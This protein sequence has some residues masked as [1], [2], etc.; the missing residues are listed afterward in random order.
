LMSAPINMKFVV[1]FHG[2][3]FVNESFCRNAKA[4]F[5]VADREC[6]CWWI[7][8]VAYDMPPRTPPPVMQ[9]GCGFVVGSLLALRHPRN[10]VPKRPERHGTNPKRPNM[11]DASQLTTECAGVYC[12]A[13]VMSNT[14]PTGIMPPLADGKAPK[15]PAP[16]S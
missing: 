16:A 2:C 9:R 13:T 6:R 15:H 1:F 4:G 11:D 7:K 14:L 8:K 10:P 12:K 5:A 3:R